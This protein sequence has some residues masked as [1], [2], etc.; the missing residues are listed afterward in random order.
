MDP[1]PPKRAHG[2]ALEAAKQPVA[3]G[4][5]LRS[6]QSVGF[7]ETLLREM[8]MLLVPKDAT[9][10]LRSAAPDVLLQAAARLGDSQRLAS[11]V[12]F[13]H[14]PAEQQEALLAMGV[15]EGSCSIR[16]T[17]RVI[18]TFLQ[19]FPVFAA[20]VDWKLFVEVVGIVSER[21]SRLANG[22]YAVYKLMDLASHSCQ[23]NAVVE[24]L[25]EDGLRELRCLSYA[26]I[27][28]NEEIS[29]SYVAEEVLL[30]PSE[31]RRATIRAER[32]GWHC[33]CNRCKLDGEVANDLRSVSAQLRRGMEVPPLRERLQA[34]KAI[35]TALPFAMAA[36]ARVRFSLAQACEAAVDQGLFEEAK[37]LYEQ[38]LDETDIVLGQK[39]LRNLANIKRRLEQLLETMA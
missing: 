37:M 17:E 10:F 36:K 35:D 25:D 8:P 18:R 39:G 28:E 22:N 1:W 38:A 33:A 7:G 31:P 19:D 11:F 27:A 30:Q 13:Q 6:R 23:P 9:A 5:H 14:L 3:D 12:A 16:E 15:P 21:G 34:L 20:A 26:G 32:G 29:T 2:R 4:P 24:T